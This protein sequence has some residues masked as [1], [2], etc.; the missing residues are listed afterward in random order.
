[1]E[2]PEWAVTAFTGLVSGDHIAARA[3]IESAALTAG[4]TAG[5]S[6]VVGKYVTLTLDFALSASGINASVVS[7]PEVVAGVTTG[8]ATR[9]LRAI[10]TEYGM[11]A[12]SIDAVVGLS[13]A[14]KP[15]KRG[16]ASLLAG[17]ASSKLLEVLNQHNVSGEMKALGLSAEYTTAVSAADIQTLATLLGNAATLSSAVSAG[18]RLASAEEQTAVGAALGRVV[19]AVSTATQ[20][21]SALRKKDLGMAV[22]AVITATGQQNTPVGKVLILFVKTASLA[23]SAIKASSLTD[24]ANLALQVADTVGLPSW[25]NTLLDGV[26]TI[27][28]ISS[29]ILAVAKTKD[30]ASIISA[31]LMLAEAVGAP[32][33]IIQMLQTVSVFAV[34]GQRLIVSISNSDWPAALSSLVQLLGADTPLVHAIESFAR[35]D[36]KKTVANVTM[37]IGPDFMAKLPNNEVYTW[38][39]RQPNTLPPTF[40][41]VF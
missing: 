2:A 20:L 36:I 3:A 1:M 41:A 19:L 21:E 13:G 24:V 40:C 9:V 17:G 35:G 37:A 11:P 12:W 39:E 16:L 34:G 27:A 5:S 7:S 31:V 10:A 26:V 28:H 8:N 30:P 25:A 14:A 18:R 29:P 23:E 6:D 32:D 4:A 22:S 33:N 15:S 38:R